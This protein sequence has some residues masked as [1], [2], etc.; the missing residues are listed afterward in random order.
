LK[1]GGGKVPHIATVDAANP[2]CAKSGRFLGIR[3][4]QMTISK[5]LGEMVRK[6]G[7]SIGSKPE[8]RDVRLRS[9]DAAQG[10]DGCGLDKSPIT[11]F[12]DDP[13]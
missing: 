10:S 1:S 5:H 6:K 7:R 2:L 4:A 11:E 8:A 13:S 9:H 12:A 3:V